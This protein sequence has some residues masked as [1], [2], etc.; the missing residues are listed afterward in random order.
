MKVVLAEKPSVARE[1]ASFLGASARREGYFEGNGYQVTWAG[2]P[3]DAEGAARLRSGPEAVVAGGAAVRA[4]AIRDQADRGGRVL[5]QIAVIRRCSA[6][7][8]S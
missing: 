8:R 5:T 1:L 6:T 7:P 3:G 4:R 2:A